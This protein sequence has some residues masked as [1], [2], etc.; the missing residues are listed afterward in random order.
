MAIW[1]TISIVI[2]W[3]K[4]LCLVAWEDFYNYIVSAMITVVRR[5]PLIQVALEVK[6]SESSARLVKARLEKTTLGQVA[7]SISMNLTASEVS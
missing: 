6:Q 3:I 1:Q 7:E 5:A 4:T 2:V